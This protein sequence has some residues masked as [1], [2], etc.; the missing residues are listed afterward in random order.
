MQYI[1]LVHLPKHRKTY[2]FHQG[3]QNRNRVHLWIYPTFL[4]HHLTIHLVYFLQTLVIEHFLRNLL[5]FQFFVADQKIYAHYLFLLVGCLKEWILDFLGLVFHMMHHI[6]C[7]Y[8]HF[9]HL[10]HTLDKSL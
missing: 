5:A 7:S 3:F 2:S 1:L 6:H 9:D 10:H 4:N 8:H